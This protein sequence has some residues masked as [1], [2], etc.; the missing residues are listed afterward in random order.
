[1]MAYGT[2]SI[3]HDADNPT[4]SI[5]C[6]LLNGLM[7]YDVSKPS[8]DYIRSMPIFWLMANNKWQ[9]GVFNDDDATIFPLY[10]SNIRIPI[11]GTGLLP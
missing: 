5:E 4:D 11:L 9:P 10:A 8:M 1:M 6:A 7:T 3:Y 2:Q